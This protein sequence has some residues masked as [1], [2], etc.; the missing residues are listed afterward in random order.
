MVIKS[1][2]CSSVTYPL[3]YSAP[4]PWTH[5]L[6]PWE[7]GIGRDLHW[8]PLR[9]HVHI[10]LPLHSDAL[11]LDQAWTPL[12]LGLLWKAM[13]RSWGSPHHTESSPS[14]MYCTRTVGRTGAGD[15]GSH[16]GCFHNFGAHPESQGLCNSAIMSHEQQTS[17][18]LCN[19]QTQLRNNNRTKT[20][21]L[22]FSVW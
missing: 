17:N 18:L 19:T 5:P 20:I 7:L 9:P 8:F 2:K 1:R 3:W 14:G 15:V 6:R 16:S 13:I 11:R 21:K 10:P 12:E 4:V 22:L